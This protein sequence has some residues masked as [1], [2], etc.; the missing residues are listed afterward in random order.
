MALRWWSVADGEKDAAYI[1]RARLL[2]GLA[3]QVLAKASHL[4]TTG[5]P[6][7]AI[8]ALVQSE[9]LRELGIDRVKFR[10]D[11]LREWAAANLLF[12]EQENIDL[13]PLKDAPHQIWRGPLS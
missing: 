13:L 5:H 8:H 11:V 1:D 3:K 2:K 12:S 9:T 4:D 7:G 10:H 6:A